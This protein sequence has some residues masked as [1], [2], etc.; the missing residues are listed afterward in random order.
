MAPYR[1][2]FFD[3]DNTLFDY[4]QAE[5]NALERTFHD[6]TLAFQPEYA[7]AYQRINQQI[8][9]DFE[10][11]QITSIQLRVRRF[12]RLFAYAGITGDAQ[13][14]SAQ[15]LANLSQQ[16]GLMPGAHEVVTRLAQTHHLAIITNGLSEVQRP[17]LAKSSIHNCFAGMFIS[18]EMG[19]A[20][21]DPA[22]FAGV[23]AALAGHPQPPEP[24]SVLVVGDSL[25][26]DI[27]GGRAAGMDTCW[28]NPSGKTANPKIQA[29]FTIGR[30]DAL[31]NIL[32]F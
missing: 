8:W 16:A 2:I 18:E 9:L 11:G 24:A 4:D 27:Q 10:R 13:A 31:Y 22:Y 32:G 15:Y 6:L 1:W 30:L 25:T 3:A 21:P 23:L 5:N 20:K 28:F 19:V 17:R 14:F 29:D 26:S 7:A 12:E